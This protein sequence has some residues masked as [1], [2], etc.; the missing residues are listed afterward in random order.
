M[1]SSSKPFDIY[2]VP[3]S[4]HEKSVVTKSKLP[5][6]RMTRST[7]PKRIKTKMHDKRD[8]QQAKEQTKPTYK[9]RPK[10]EAK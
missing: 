3:N 10:R 5:S 1:G 7:I 4:D 8:A 2:K 9:T 6:T